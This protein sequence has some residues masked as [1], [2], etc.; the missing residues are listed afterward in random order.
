MLAGGASVLGMGASFVADAEA[1]HVPEHLLTSLLAAG[2]LGAVAVQPIQAAWHWITP[3]IIPSHGY[4]VREAVLRS[5]V[6]HLS[7]VPAA[8]F[9][10]VAG[11]YTLDAVPVERARERFLSSWGSVVGLS[12]GVGIGW[13]LTDAFAAY[14]DALPRRRMIGAFTVGALYCSA[15]ALRT[16]QSARDTYEEKAHPTGNFLELGRWRTFS[17]DL[18]RMAELRNIQ[19]SRRSAPAQK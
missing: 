10:A 15:V 17:P 19:S 9:V 14:C 13:Q 6:C 18:D 16:R 8:S 11:L 2:A 3:R 5:T 12:W 4:P 1:I 7:A